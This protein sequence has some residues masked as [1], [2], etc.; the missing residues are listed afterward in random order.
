M[1][2]LNCKNHSASEVSAFRIIRHNCT[3]CQFVNLSYDTSFVI[4]FALGGEGMARSSGGTVVPSYVG[5][6]DRY[7]DGYQNGPPGSYSEQYGDR[8]QSD[9]SVGLLIM[10][11]LHNEVVICRLQMWLRMNA[12]DIQCF[13]NLFQVDRDNPTNMVCHFLSSWQLCH[14][15]SSH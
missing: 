9:R 3:V 4:I 8:Y 7:E 1:D 5:G 14:V 12:A 2:E 15:N 11:P 6:A 10:A 13:F